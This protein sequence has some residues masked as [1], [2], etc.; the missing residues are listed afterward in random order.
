MAKNDMLRRLEAKYDAY[1]SARFMENVR[2]L[3]QMAQDAAMIAAHD[4][5]GMGRGR[6]EAFAEAY[7]QNMNDMA[8]LFNGDTEDLEY[9]RYKIEQQMQKICGDKYEPWDVRYEKGV[10]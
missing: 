4:V 1:Y 7:R 9:S 10:I 3:C 6:C 8:H 2:T 5:L